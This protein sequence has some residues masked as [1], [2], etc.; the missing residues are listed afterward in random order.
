MT[1]ELFAF[2]RVGAEF[3]ASR[4]NALLA[5]EMGL[6][7]SAQAIAA[8]DMIGAES[9]LVITPTSGRI[10][11]LREFETFS[12]VTRHKAVWEPGKPIR[13]RSVLTVGWANLNDALPQ[14]RNYR[15]DLIIADEAH[16]A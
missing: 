11:W 7:K 9:I 1:T 16:Y 13:P 6:G 8:A 4:R 10:H 12:R 2:Q 3:L 15:W 14:L 5:D